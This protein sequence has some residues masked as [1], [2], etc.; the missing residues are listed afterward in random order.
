MSHKE[1][2]LLKKS[3]HRQ[4]GFYSRYS[5]SIM[6]TCWGFELSDKRELPFNNETQ[7]VF[8]FQKEFARFV[9]T[10]LYL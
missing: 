9:L 2:Q 3:W 1:Q 4:W 8:L 6:A 7:S 10:L 5:L